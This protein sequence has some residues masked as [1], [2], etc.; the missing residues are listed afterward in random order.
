MRYYSLA[1]TG[2]FM[3]S[4]RTLFLT[5]ALF[6]SSA[7]AQAQSLQSTPERHFGPALPFNT[8]GSDDWP[9]ERIGPVALPDGRLLLSRFGTVFMLDATGKQ[10]WKYETDSENESLTSEPAYNAETNEIGIVGYDLLFVRLDAATGKEK[11]RASTV[12]DAV[13]TRVTA[14]GRGFLVVVNMAHYRENDRMEHL[15]Y[16]TSDRLEYWGETK[17]VEW[18]ADFPIGAQLLVSGKQIYACWR[19]RGGL[20]LRA[21]RQVSTQ[22]Q[23]AN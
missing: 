11:W 16:R 10:L 5:I 18:S 15:K 7:F 14:Y 19:V 6:S 4:T 12:G 2:I 9:D 20:K 3:N 17:D 22:R 21:L 13:F 1:A 23:S 8:E